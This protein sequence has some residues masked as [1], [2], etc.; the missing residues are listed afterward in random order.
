M[1]IPARFYST[2]IRPT[3]SESQSIQHEVEMNIAW[4]TSFLRLLSKSSLVIEY[5]PST[6]MTLVPCIMSWIA[7]V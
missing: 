3:L 2:T 4:F 1:V 5:Q 6:L 7:P